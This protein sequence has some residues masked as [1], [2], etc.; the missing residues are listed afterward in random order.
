[1]TWFN[2]FAFPVPRE[3]CSRPTQRRSTFR[4]TDGMAVTEAKRRRS[5]VLVFAATVVVFATGLIDRT[6]VSVAGPG[7]EIN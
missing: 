5:K 2:R 6:I 3:L 7:G 1:V 4:G